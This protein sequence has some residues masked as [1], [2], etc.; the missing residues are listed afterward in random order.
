MNPQPD[1]INLQMLCVDC[2]FGMA[3]GGI[4]R[5]HTIHTTDNDSH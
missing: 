3:L 4:A 2:Q 5:Y 1:H